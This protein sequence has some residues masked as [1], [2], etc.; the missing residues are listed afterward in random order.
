MVLVLLEMVHIYHAKYLAFVLEQNV[1]AEE[2]RE[3][4]AEKAKSLREG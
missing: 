1:T 3:I 4:I 2:Y